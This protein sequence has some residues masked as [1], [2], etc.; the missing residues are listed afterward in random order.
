MLIHYAIT[1][2]YIFRKINQNIHIGVYAYPLPTL[3]KKLK[4]IYLKE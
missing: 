2:S 1:Y 4:V 3:I